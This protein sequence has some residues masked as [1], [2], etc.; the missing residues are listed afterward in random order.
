MEKSSG[1]GFGFLQTPGLTFAETR[2]FCQLRNPG[3]R[4]LQTR[5][6]GVV[7]LYYNNVLT[8]K[9]NC[10]IQMLAPKSGFR[11][12]APGLETP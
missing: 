9:V 11:K 5:I 12:R 10:A 6:F 3:F 1:F 8:F 4:R 7:F 2:K